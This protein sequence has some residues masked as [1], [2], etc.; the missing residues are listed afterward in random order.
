MNYFSKYKTSRLS[1]REIYSYL[2]YLCVKLQTLRW[3]RVTEGE[4]LY[5]NI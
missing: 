3:A 2:N 5:Y 1:V 4:S